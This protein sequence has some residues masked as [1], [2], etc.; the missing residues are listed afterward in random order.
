MWRRRARYRERD[1]WPRPPACR[2]WLDCER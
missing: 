1:T 2:T